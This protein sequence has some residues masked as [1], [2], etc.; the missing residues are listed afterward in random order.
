[1]AQRLIPYKILCQGGLRDL[2]DARTMNYEIMTYEIII[3]CVNIFPCMDNSGTKWHI[4]YS[5]PQL[6]IPY[7]SHISTNVL[8]YC[9]RNPYKLPIL[10]IALLSVII[11]GHKFCGPM[12]LLYSSTS[13]TNAYAITIIYKTVHCQSP[14][15]LFNYAQTIEA[16]KWQTNKSV[17]ANNTK[18]PRK[19]GPYKHMV[20]ISLIKRY[21]Y[22]AS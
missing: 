21:C 6:P 9:P 15:I 1:M 17:S 7:I 12:H 11:L 13:N 4:I 22:N 19:R 18:V 20:S 2:N 14:S 10:A 5:L 8:D 16:I 3:M